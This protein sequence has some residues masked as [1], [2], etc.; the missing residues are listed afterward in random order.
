[1]KRK[2]NSQIS[3]EENAAKKSRKDA[4]ESEEESIVSTA[5]DNQVKIVSHKFS[6]LV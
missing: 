2:S 6:F 4:D 3:C 5:S 1:M